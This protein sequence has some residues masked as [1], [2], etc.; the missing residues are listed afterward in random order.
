MG[1]SCANRSSLIVAKIGEQ[2]LTNKSIQYSRCETGSFKV[3]SKISRGSA[4]RVMGANIIPAVPAVMVFNSVL[5]F[6]GYDL[7]YLFSFSV[8]TNSFYG[9]RLFRSMNDGFRSIF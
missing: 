2:I 9:S 4:A 6:I 3:V 7:D 5:L 8:P 1:M